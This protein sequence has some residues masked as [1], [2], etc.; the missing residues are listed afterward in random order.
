LEEEIDNSTTLLDQFDHELVQ[1]ETYRDPTQLGGI[2]KSRRELK[3][4]IDVLTR[5][6]ESVAEQLHDLERQFEASKPDLPMK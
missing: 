4:K 5:E 3:E 6:W 2:H 1:P